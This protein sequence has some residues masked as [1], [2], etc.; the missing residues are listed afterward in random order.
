MRSKLFAT[1]AMLG[2]LALAACD[3]GAPQTP[4]PTASTPAEPTAASTQPTQ[5]VGVTPKTGAATETPTA[6]AAQPTTDPRTD[7]PPA[8]QDEP[9]ELVPVTLE[10]NDRTRTGAFAT[11]RTL[12]LPPGFGI[13]VYATGLGRVRWLGLSPQGTVFATVM[14]EGRVVTLP[15][16]D[17]DGVADEVK[18]FAEGLPGV[19]GLAFNGNG[20]Y[21]ATE[22]EIIRLEDA[23]GD[24]AA[25]KRDVLASDLPSGGGHSTRTL[26]FGPDGKLYVAAGSSCNVCE[27][28]DEKRAAVSRY[29]TDGKFE[30]I[31]AEGLRNAVGLEFNRESGE[32]WATNN[33]RDRLGDNLPNE[34]I[35]RVTEGGNYGWPYCYPDNGKMVPD[36]DIAPEAGFC[37]RVIPPAV[38]MQA[39]SAPLGLD[40]YTGDL[41]PAQFKG[42]MFVA[43]HGSWNRTEPTGYKVVRIRFNNNQPAEGAGEALV[44]DFATGWLVGGQEWGRPLDLLTLPNGTMLLT[45]DSTNAIYQIYYQ[46]N[47]GP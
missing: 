37:E 43:F 31:F 32:L 35:Y 41:F 21:V 16:A 23:D 33:G 14:G 40:F 17:N 7:P 2:A 45:D 29:S 20:V 38:S 22:T 36:P 19:H 42:D 28:A 12:N 6:G 3:V 46:E 11:E 13:R 4:N 5:E 34:A 27:E 25:E 15:D 9:L 10:T 39:H 30:K 1:I 18:T 44:E 26:A 24:G 47:A 8:T